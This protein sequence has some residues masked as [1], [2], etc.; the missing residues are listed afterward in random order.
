[1]KNL[2]QFV[3]LAREVNFYPRV[4]TEMANSLYAMKPYEKEEQKK[5]DK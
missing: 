3:P 2:T 4:I 1:M 5:C